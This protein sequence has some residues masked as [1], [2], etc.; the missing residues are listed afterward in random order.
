MGSRLDFSQPR[1]TSDE[2]N[3]RDT[4]HAAKKWKC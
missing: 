4:D 2:V 3:R 1:V